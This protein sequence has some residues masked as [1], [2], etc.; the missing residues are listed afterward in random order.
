MVQVSYD[1]ADGQINWIS[2]FN[3]RNQLRDY[4][5]VHGKGGDEIWVGYI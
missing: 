1:G 5:M 3:A 4:S 2:P